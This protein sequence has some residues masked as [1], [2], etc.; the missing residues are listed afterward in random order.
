MIARCI[1]V[2]SLDGFLKA[3]TRALENT[4]RSRYGSMLFYPLRHFDLIHPGR[5][6]EIPGPSARI[7]TRYRRY[8]CDILTFLRYRAGVQRETKVYERGY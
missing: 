6:L 4:L 1:V 5:S 3:Q 8:R 7:V 2:R